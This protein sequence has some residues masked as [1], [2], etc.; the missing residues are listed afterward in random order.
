MAGL[1]GLVILGGIVIGI[2]AVVR[3]RLGRADGSGDSGD[4]MAY[5]L[6]ALAF[7]T[8]AFSLA[9]LGRTAFPGDTFVFDTTTQVATAL[10]GLVVSAPIAFFLWRRQAERRSTHTSDAGWIVYLALME[11]IFLT[12]FVV[13]ATQLVSWALGTSD[14]PKWTDVLVFGAWW[15]STSWSLE[16]HRQREMGPSCRVW[17][18]PQSGSFPRRSALVEFSTGFSTGCTP[19]SHHRQA[20]LTSRFG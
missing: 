14:N 16:R 19:L 17:W 7:G 10:A 2:I 3:N 13:V 20:K 8:A 5:L 12:A 6:L 4:V 18:A 1:V 11:G 9:S 15:F